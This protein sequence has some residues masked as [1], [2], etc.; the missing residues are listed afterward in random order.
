MEFCLRFE[1]FT[2]FLNPE[3]LSQETGKKKVK[4]T[5]YSKFESVDVGDA[6]DDDGVE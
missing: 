1:S 2:A 6:D 5:I 4:N 3:K